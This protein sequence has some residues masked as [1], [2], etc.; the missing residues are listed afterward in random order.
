MTNKCNELGL[1]Q[2]YIKLNTEESKLQ[3]KYKPRNEKIM[4]LKERRK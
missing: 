2:I 3:K 4:C 1:R